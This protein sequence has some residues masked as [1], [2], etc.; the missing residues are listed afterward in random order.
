MLEIET[1]EELDF[2][3]I[4]VGTVDLNNSVSIDV[5]ESVDA[6]NAY[7]LF[8]YNMD[9]TGEYVHLDVYFKDTEEVMNWYENIRENNN[10]EDYCELLEEYNNEEDA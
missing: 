8:I 5:G 3:N 6:N 7:E 1:I 10:L 2:D 4:T 9:G